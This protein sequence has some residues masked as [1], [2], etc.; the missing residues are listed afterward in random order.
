[1]RPWETE[2]IDRVI[3]RLRSFHVPCRSR[4]IK[5]I[6]PSNPMLISG[7]LVLPH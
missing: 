6:S 4:D 1:M 3:I 5:L 7:R 2:R